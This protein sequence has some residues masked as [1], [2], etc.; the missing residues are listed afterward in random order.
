MKKLLLLLCVLFVLVFCACQITVTTNIPKEFSPSP[1]STKTPKATKEPQDSNLLGRVEGNTYIN[2]ELGLSATIPDGWEVADAEGLSYIFKLSADIMKETAGL[3]SGAEMGIMYC[4]ENGVYSVDMIPNI[5][6]VLSNKSETMA[7]IRS[8]DAFDSFLDQ[9]RTMI[10]PVFPDCEVEA[11]GERSVMMGNY[12]YSVFH[13]I[14][15]NESGLR[16]YEDQYFKPVEDYVLII[17][18]SYYDTAEKAVLDKF[19]ESIEYES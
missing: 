18:T 7:I 14:F 19:I 11:E 10:G 2:E 9:Y 3:E 17:T 8:Q 1:V 12:E 5:N 6:F 4:S 15:E 16:F 13:I